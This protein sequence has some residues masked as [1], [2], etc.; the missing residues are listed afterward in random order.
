MA[1]R[2]RLWAFAS[3]LAICLLAGLARVG[4]AQ[5]S[6][7]SREAAPLP[8]TTTQ[9]RLVNPTGLSEPSPLGWHTDFIGPLRGDFDLSFGVIVWTNRFQFRNLIFGGTVDLLPGIRARGQFRR[10]EDD[11][12]VFQ[13]DTDEAYLE[14]YN[15]YRAPTWNAG[16]DLRIGRSRYL[17]FPYPDAIAI[18]DQVPGIADLSAPVATDY[19]DVLLQAE[20]ALNSG[21]GVHGTGLARGFVSGHGINGRVVEAYGF[22]RSNFGRGWHV[23]GRAGWLAVR[24]EPLGRAGQPGLSAYVGKQL[25]EFNVGL[26]YEK[27]RHE[28]EY[29]GIMVQFRPGPVTRALGRVSFDYDRHP[30]GF[31]LQIPVWHGRLNESRFVRSGDILVGEVRAVR[32]RT[33]W[34][35]GYVRNQ[36]EH[37]LESWGETSDPRLHCVVIEEPWYLQAEALVSPHLVPDARWERDRQGP[38]QYVQRVTYRFY[39]PYRRSPG[40]A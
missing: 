35:Q 24:R 7:T 8:P 27:K 20:L 23:E 12:K 11:D 21:W 25:G 15:Q 38:A 29:S 40:G 4:K 1:H 18:F 9:E 34:Q 30:E 26:L 31:S 39:R 5:A 19:R 13:V 3:A 17:H 2:R 37:R 32:I 10:R 33:L 22:Y 28:S 14:A 36:Y 16:V 6:Q